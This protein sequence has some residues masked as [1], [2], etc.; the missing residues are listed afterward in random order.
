MNCVGVAL[1]GDT[2]WPAYIFR[3]A[4]ETLVVRIMLR[5]CCCLADEQHGP[6]LLLVALL[7]FKLLLVFPPFK[8]GLC[9]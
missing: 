3:S 7:V 1:H 5:S 4:A 8:V 2:A 6:T 9:L